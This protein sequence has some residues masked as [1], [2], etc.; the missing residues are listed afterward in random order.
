MK[1]AL[2]GSYEVNVSRDE[3]GVEPFT[4]RVTAYIRWA[5][6]KE[7]KKVQTLLLEN[8]ELDLEGVVFDWGA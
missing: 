8:R 5:C 6:G 7:D 3:W 1:S 4:V 2:L